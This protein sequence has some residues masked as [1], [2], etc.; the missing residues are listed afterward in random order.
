MLASEG[1]ATYPTLGPSTRFPPRTA[2]VERL[3]PAG[4]NEPQVFL[5]MERRPT[6]NPASGSEWEMFVIGPDGK[7]IERGDLPACQRC[8]AEAPQEGV[9][10]EAR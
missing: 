2:L 4:S 1:A 6:P 7:S 9:F 3:Y 5:A 8:H 10:G